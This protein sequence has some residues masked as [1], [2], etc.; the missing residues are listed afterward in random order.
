[1][2]HRVE[3]ARSVY[4]A[5]KPFVP[6]R[7]WIAIRH[8][9][10]L[11]IRSRCTDIWPIDERAG[12]APEGW[13]GWPEGKEFA[14]VITHDVES[15]KGQKGCRELMELDARFG[16]RS[17]FNFV[18]EGYPRDADLFQHLRGNGFEVGLHGLKH[19]GNL[20]ASKEAFLRQVPRIN[21][22]LREWGA[23]GFR[24]P[25]MYHN[26][27]WIRH[28]EVEYDASTFDTDPFEPQPDAVGTIFPFWVPGDSRG[29]GYVELPYTLPQDSTLFL[30]LKEKGIDIWKEKLNWIAKRGGMV[31][32]N[33][34]P[35][36]MRFD[37]TKTRVDEYPARYYEEFLEYVSS[38]YQGRFWHVLPK[39]MAQFWMKDCL[40]VG[41]M[42]NERSTDQMAPF[43]T[44]SRI[45]RGQ[46]PEMRRRSR[47]IVMLVENNFP[48]DPR[49]K[50]E[51]YTLTKTGH[52]VTVISLG[53]SGQRFEEYLDGVHVYR[54]PRLTFFRK[55]YAA[56]PSPAQR[57]VNYAKSVLGYVVEYTYFTSM[58]LFFVLYILVRRGFD[59]IHAHNPPDTLFLV[60]IV[61][62]LLGKKFVFDHHD[63]SPELYLSR[64][65]SSNSI[66]YRALVW[67]ERS[68]LRISD[69]VIAT[70]ESYKGLEVTRGGISPE[71]IFVVRNGPD[72]NRVKRGPPAQE[73]KQKGKLILGYAGSMNPQDGVDY[74]IRAIRYLV[75]E[76]GRRDFFSV[77]VGGGDSLEYLKALTAKLRIEDYVEYT[78]FLPLEELLP[79]LSAADICL[80]PDPSSPLNDK[81]TFVKVMEYMALG[82]PIVSFDLKETRFTAQESSVYVPPNDEAEY[83][84]AIARLMDDPELRAKMGLIG[85]Q[86]IERE[87]NW[88]IV[89]QNLVSAYEKLRLPSSTPSTRYS[90]FR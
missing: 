85:K 2:P 47:R 74:A 56:N 23:V 38:E 12:R 19:K 63:L 89:G 80:N 54:M 62:K 55:T 77:F 69:M 60:G 87:L 29:R 36:Y 27:D 50:N 11:R 45:W 46:N 7:L 42:P 17:S 52:E 72:L 83:A 1:M 10:S 82:K 67:L 18:A 86:R 66:I 34:H 35:D 84:R 71:K 22:Y 44:T 76:L 24:A 26:L 65:K 32:L 53:Q 51:A 78:G 81:S 8:K 15:T 64:F 30:F 43:V 49:V 31:L 28:L 9:L 48:M 88:E 14:L 90:F 4:Y 21:Q 39:E 79:Y 20:F 25:A 33:A 13:R 3:F 75:Y 70:N 40:E 59:V 58:C 41:R 68:S 5:I 16:F 73:L 57:I 61:G 37:S 6:K